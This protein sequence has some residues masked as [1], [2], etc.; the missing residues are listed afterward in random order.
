MSP[1]VGASLPVLPSTVAARAREDPLGGN[2]PAGAAF[3]WLRAGWRDLTIQPMLS[4]AYGFAVCL[5]S[6]AVIW[7]LFAFGLDYI[8]FP[9]LAGFMVVGP[10]LAIGLYEKSRDRK[11]VV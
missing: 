11:S 1:A 4:L 9:A 6:V 3:G 10:V 5:V 2:L 7:G 8:L